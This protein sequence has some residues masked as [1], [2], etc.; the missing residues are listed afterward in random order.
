MS[1]R[2]FPL[3]LRGPKDGRAAKRPVKLGLRG[4]SHI[5]IVDGLGQGDV[6]IPQSSGVVTGQ[7]IRPVLP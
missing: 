2:V 4:N 5:E 3:P 6:A 1:E 7:R